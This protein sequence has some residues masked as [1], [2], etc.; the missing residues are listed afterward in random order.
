MSTM[1]TSFAPIFLAS[2]TPIRPTPPAPMTTTASSFKV[3]IFF[4]AENAVTPE[5]ASGA[6]SVGFRPLMS[7]R[8]RWLGTSMCVA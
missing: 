4:S 5:Q 7:N 6:A 1:I 8:W 2:V 3:G